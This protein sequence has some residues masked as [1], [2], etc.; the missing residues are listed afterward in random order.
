MKTPTLALLLPL[1]GTTTAAPS[2]RAA[3]SRQQHRRAALPY[4]LSH[5][6]IPSIPGPT[7]FSPNTK[8]K[9][10]AVSAAAAPP[11]SQIAGARLLSPNTTSVSAVI[12]IPFAELP[13][14]GPTAGNENGLYQATY[15]VGIDGLTS[16]SCS[17]RSLRAGVDTFWDSGSQSAGAWWE[18]YPQEGPVLFADLEV[19]QGDVVRIT[20][21]ADA[22]GAGGEAVVEKLA[23]LECGSE[24]LAT[25][26]QRFDGIAAGNKLCLAEAEWVVEDYPILNRPDYPLPLA[27]FSVVEFERVKVNGQLVGE[28]AEVFD[29]HL[30]AQGGRLTDCDFEG[31][32]GR[33]QC[34]RVVGDA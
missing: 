3:S 21:T 20:V 10:F 5:V 8:S 25:G 19:D 33:V 18:W 28:G 34:K 29:I 6:P 1:L 24:V 9:S 15:W 30:E 2:S 26:R 4:E 32:K 22:D 27:N 13:T 7:F 17:G 14:T 11:E 31:D 16:T 12:Q 23:G